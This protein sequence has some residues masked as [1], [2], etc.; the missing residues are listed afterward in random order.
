MS[1][2]PKPATNPA[3]ARAQHLRRVALVLDTET[4]GS[5]RTHDEVIELG[6]VRAL[7]GEVLINQRFRPT[8][9]IEPGAFRVHGISERHLMGEPRFDSRWEEYYALLNNQIVIG[10]NVKYDQ[11][12][13]ETT[14]RKYNLDVPR[15]EWVDLMPLY[16]DFKRA[17]KTCKLSVAC[18]EQGVKAGDHSAKADALATARVLHKIAGKE[19]APEVAQQEELFDAVVT[20]EWELA[21]VGDYYSDEPDETETDADAPKMLAEPPTG[22]AEAYLRDDG[23]ICIPM[24]A[25][26]VLR[27]WLPGSQ[28]L[29]VTLA[30]LNAPLA[31]W[32]QYGKR[33]ENLLTDA[34]AGYCKGTV[35]QGKGFW[36]CAGCGR[37]MDGGAGNGLL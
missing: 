12:M 27:W 32:K 7:D 24:D 18:E 37:W 28:S 31:G 17:A 13:L 30:E 21:D 23:S 11:Q 19:T 3:I 5:N 14:C 10:W 22:T 6:V 33:E 34:H 15:V 20:H 2:L 8:K 9:N 36:F 29:F 26:P 4:T 16:R 35:Q 1:T 25:R